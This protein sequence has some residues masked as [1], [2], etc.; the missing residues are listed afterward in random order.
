MKQVISALWKHSQALVTGKL[1][2]CNYSWRVCSYL[3]Q[4]VD[5]ALVDKLIMR[6]VCATLMNAK[7]VLIGHVC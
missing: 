6:R 7:Q 1:L 4:A 2:H 3:R 5:V